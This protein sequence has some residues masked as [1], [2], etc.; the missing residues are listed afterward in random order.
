MR[1]YTYEYEAAAKGEHAEA[2]M[3][4][5]NTAEV[6]IKHMSHFDAI[7]IL[8]G[9]VPVVHIECEGDEMLYINASHIDTI[10]VFE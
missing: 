8:N 7:D 9:R 2:A 3:S 5:G 10:R 6:R 4:V 1:H